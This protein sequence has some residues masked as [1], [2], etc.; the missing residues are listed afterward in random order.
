MAK[1]V[2][3]PNGT[4]LPLL[5]LKGKDY[6]MV[7][8]RIQWFN[9]VEKFFSIDTVFLLLDEEQT[10]CRATVHIKDAAGNI[11]RS[12]SATKRETKKDFSD[13]TE[14]AETS[15]IG[16]AITLLG[17]G[18]QFALADLDEGM[19]L[20]DSPV[21]DVKGNGAVNNSGAVKA[22]TADSTTLISAEAVKAISPET[23]KP[24]TNSFKK[25]GTVATQTATKV[26][27]G[28]WQ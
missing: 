20:A 5:S 15:A 28:G 22:V 4:A 21:L 27:D 24:K 7:A 16:R 17:Y 13:H 8:H 12:T 23:E 11:V 10:I 2:N 18:T 14:K 9:E 25:P 19:R 6:M 1:V 26:D 3:T